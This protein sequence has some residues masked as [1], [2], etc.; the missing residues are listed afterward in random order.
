MT[1]SL[2][3]R[4]VL[5]SVSVFLGSLFGGSALASTDKGCSAT[6]SDIQGPFYLAGAPRRATLADARE[7]GERIRIRG[8]VF[9][10][11]CAS[12][13]AG[14]LLDI[15]HADAQGNYHDAKERYR[16]RGQI[17]TDA[18]GRYEFETVRP[19][20]Y[21]LEDGWRPAHIHFTISSPGYHPLTTQ[22]YFRGDPYLGPHD[23][24]GEECHSDD[25]HRTI[26]LEPDGAR[27]AGRFDVVLNSKRV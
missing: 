25:P 6:T 11:D 3:R 4:S 1:Q 13:L 9:A 5:R 15:W 2:D 16:L 10:S 17:L 8:T 7:P 20:H 24:C 23:A 22:L 19:G 26:S 18:L 14:T 12:P 21:K 27:L